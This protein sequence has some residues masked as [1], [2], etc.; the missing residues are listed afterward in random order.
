MAV[1]TCFVS[2]EKKASE[3][4]FP[5]ITDSQRRRMKHVIG[6]IAIIT[7]FIQNDLIRRK[8]EHMIRKRAVAGGRWQAIRSIYSTGWHASVTYM[9]DR[10]DREQDLQVRIARHHTGYQ[11]SIFV[12]N[13]I[14]RKNPAVEAALRQFMTI[15]DY[16]PCFFSVHIHRQCR[17][18]ASASQVRGPNG[19]PATSE[20]L[21]FQV[22]P[23]AMTQRTKP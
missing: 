12:H 14:Y 1:I 10:A 11:R 18:S 9:P 8:V 5:Q 22:L 20:C 17:K 23:P 16:L 13:L 19:E 6:I 2:A 7:Q 15:G 3:K 21:S 4:A